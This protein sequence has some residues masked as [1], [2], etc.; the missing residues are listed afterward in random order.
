MINNI[1]LKNF[2][3]HKNTQMELGNINFLCGQ[4]GVGKSSIIQSLLLLRQTFLKGR[5][6]KILSLNHP[7]CYVGTGADA[8][9]QYAEND[10]ITFEVSYNNKNLKWIFDAK[11]QAS[12]FIEISKNHTAITEN[13]QTIPLFNYDF[14]YISA[15]RVAEYQSDD[16]AVEVEKQISVQE[17]K[18]EL[19]AQFLFKYQK[20]QVNHALLHPAGKEGNADL[21]YHVT[22][23]QR[24]ISKG[25]NV[26]PKKVGTSYE[27]VY[28]FERENNDT[29]QEFKSKN[30]GF[31]LSYTLP[32][33]V[34]ILSAEPNSLLLIENPEAHLHPYAQAKITELMCLASQNGIQIFCETHSDHIING[35]LVACK[36]QQIDHENIKIWYFDRNETEHVATPIAINVLEGGRIDNQPKGFFDQIKKDLKIIMGF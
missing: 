31:G 22:L 36:K 33:V 3:S 23:W 35:A 5:L 34:A 19:T 18:A 10:E 26:T 13:L 2:K 7:F 27:V 12:D 32:I 11:R 15:G 17:G 6:D 4:N 14:Q 28:S 1:S 8:L 9:Y 25:V 16:Y 20:L 24:E 21:L 29:T 30:V